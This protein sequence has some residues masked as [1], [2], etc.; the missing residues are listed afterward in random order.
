MDYASTLEGLEGFSNDLVW[1]SKNQVG[2]R[3]IFYPFVKVRVS[4]ELLM[5]V[6]KAPSSIYIDSQSCKIDGIHEYS[7]GP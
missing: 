6:N 4:P 2:A 1:S 7:G 5:V 3:A